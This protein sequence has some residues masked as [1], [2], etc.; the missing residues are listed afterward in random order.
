MFLEA[1]RW[2]NGHEVSLSRRVNKGNV[3]YIVRRA[4]AEG[5][6]VLVDGVQW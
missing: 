5:F 1:I 3:H 4:K 6:T 2:E